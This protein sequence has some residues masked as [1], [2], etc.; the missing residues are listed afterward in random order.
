MR[1]WMAVW[2]LLATAAWAQNWEAGVLGGGGFYINHP[3]ISGAS[4]SAAAGI[5]DGPAF[6]AF[7]TQNLYRRLSG[8]IRY[9]YHRGDLELSSG[10]RRASFRADSHA[11]HYDWVFHLAGREAKVRPYVAAGAGLKLYRGTGT[12]T[13]VQTLQEVALLTRTR[14]WKPLV[15]AGI[16]VMLALSR[17]VRLRLE[18]RDY[19]TPFPKRVIAPVE[20]GTVGW[21]HDFSPTLGLSIRF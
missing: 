3:Q 5:G 7:L 8:E 1:R 17:S 14:E 11:L 13:L 10:S 16:G 9:V 4:G 6:G 2:L 21:L 20:G 12:E 15:S 19:M 18:F